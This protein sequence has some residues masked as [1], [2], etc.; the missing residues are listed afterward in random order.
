MSF[1][2]LMQSWNLKNEDFVWI[3]ND[4]WW[5]PFMNGILVGC[6]LVQ[7]LLV[8][9]FGPKISIKIV[10]TL[11]SDILAGKLK[12]GNEIK[13]FLVFLLLLSSYDTQL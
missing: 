6:I 2:I 8:S 1:F 13:V 7:A 5:S 11:R 12:S 9:D 3:D 4:E 10:D